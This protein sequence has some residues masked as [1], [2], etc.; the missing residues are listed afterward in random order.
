MRCENCGAPL[1]YLGKCEYCG[2]QNHIHITELLDR[3]VQDGVL[4]G[5]YMKVEVKDIVYETFRDAKG[6]IMPPIIQHKRIV[7]IYEE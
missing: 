3:I 5:G 4:I 6:N 2:T 1:D 7:T